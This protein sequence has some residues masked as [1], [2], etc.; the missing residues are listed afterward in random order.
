MQ[1]GSLAAG[2]GCESLDYRGVRSVDLYQYSR[3]SP[4]FAAFLAEHRE[5]TLPFVGAGISVDAGVPAADHLAKLIAE[6]AR[7]ERATIG[8]VANFAGV[9]GGVSEQ[10]GH[11]RLQELTAAI[12]DALPLTPTPLQ[13]LIVRC[14]LGVVLT[15]NFEPSIEMAA[16][17]A[18][19]EPIPRT[20]D[21]ALARERPGE[22]Q[23][24]IV[25]LHGRTSAPETMVL[26][27]D[28]LEALRG[29]ERFKTTLRGLVAPHLV[30]YLGYRLPSEDAYLREE[31]ELLA[32][33]FAD[34]GPHAVLIPS[35]EYE[36]PPG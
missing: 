30:I 32:S 11:G 24:V 18:G 29:D 22:G 31:I 17:E 5:R 13:R 27:G 7:K 36:D 14:P 34:R 15:S 3:I 23:V 16:R 1:P 4:E 9:C 12:L 8:E 21:Q 2:A 6:E 25:Y 33:M 19:L 20:P 26:P 10:L 35:D 28:S